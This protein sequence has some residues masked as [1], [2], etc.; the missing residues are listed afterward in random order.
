MPHPHGRAAGGAR[1]NLSA[2][3]WSQ[4]QPG[5]AFALTW[6]S[7]D[8]DPQPG[9]SAR[10]TAGAALVDGERF[11]PDICSAARCPP[12]AR[13]V[14]RRA[15]PQCLS[16]S[17]LLPARAS[18]CAGSRRWQPTPTRPPPPA[19]R[20]PPG[21][22]R[23]AATPLTTLATFLDLLQKGD[24]NRAQD[25]VAR[26]DLL[27][28]AAR[29]NMV[30]PGDWM[31]VYVNDQD[32]EIQDES[33]SLRIRFFDNADRNRTYEALFEQNAESGQ[34]QRAAIGQ[35]CWPPAAPAW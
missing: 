6:R 7:A 17:R 25:L 2:Y 5:A 33:T 19:H 20:L 13:C 28:E 4:P 9:P 32:R 14:R 31:A 30:A 22:H 3:V 34:D 15:Y 26:L 8:E 24:A 12:T 11:L 29:L 10:A 16:S 27:S 18:P 21:R 1:A 23:G 35:S